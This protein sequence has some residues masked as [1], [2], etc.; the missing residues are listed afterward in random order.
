MCHS[1]EVIGTSTYSG[2]ADVSGKQHCVF[3]RIYCGS[4]EVVHVPT[5]REPVFVS[6]LLLIVVA[7]SVSVCN[8]AAAPRA[9]IARLKLIKGE[10]N[11]LGFI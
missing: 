3:D 2:A 7:V 1:A 10:T 6:A 4:G 5:A 9:S 11:S 8:P